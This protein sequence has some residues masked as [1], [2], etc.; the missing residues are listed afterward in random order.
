MYS[1]MNCCS[2][3]DASSAENSAEGAGGSAK[4]HVLHSIRTDNVAPFIGVSA[5][6]HAPILDLCNSRAARKPRRLAALA[7]G[8][9]DRESRVVDTRAILQAIQDVSVLNNP[10]VHANFRSTTPRSWEG[11]PIY[12]LSVAACAP[13]RSSRREQ[14]RQSDTRIFDS[15]KDSMSF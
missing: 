2:S 1:R 14:C 6:H 12:L 7:C 9:Y 11:S 10:Y 13:P 5:S 3:S 8:L 4:A 15:A